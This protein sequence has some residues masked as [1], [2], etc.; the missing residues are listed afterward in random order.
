MS[1]IFR[2]RNYSDD[3]KLKVDEHRDVIYPLIDSGVLEKRFAQITLHFDVNGV[4]RNIETKGL[5][6]VKDT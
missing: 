6:I 3:R 1:T 2:P 4:L 5:Y